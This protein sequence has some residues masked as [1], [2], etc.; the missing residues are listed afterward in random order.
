MGCAISPLSN[1]CKPEDLAE[2]IGIKVSEIDNVSSLEGLSAEELYR[3]GIVRA[4]WRAPKALLITD[5]FSDAKSNRSFLHRELYK[6]AK[7]QNIELILLTNKSSERNELWG[8][9]IDITGFVEHLLP[10][11]LITSN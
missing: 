5:S 7:D 11:E 6:I 4:L 1:L 10:E 8:Q 9:E 3:L 2:R